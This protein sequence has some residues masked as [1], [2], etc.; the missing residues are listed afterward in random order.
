MRVVTWNI[1]FGKGRDGRVD[2]RR[3][4]DTARA[5]ADFDVLCLQEVAANHPTL[6]DGAGEDQPAR[7]AELL[8][9][10][11]MVFRPAIEAWH[12]EARRFGNAIFTRLPVAQVL[13]HLL[14]RPPQAAAKSMQRQALEVVVEA[15][16][17]PVRVVTT[18]LEYYSAE[19][20]AAQVGRLRELHRETAQ[21]A[22]LGE[23][24]GAEEGPYETLPRPASAIYCGDFNFEPDWPDYAAM[25]APFESGVPAL[26][27]AWAT[28]HRGAPHPPTCGID[29]PKQWPKGPHCRDFFFLTEVLAGRMRE[30]RADTE[31]PASDHQPVL[32]RLE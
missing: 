10:Y 26:H 24:R 18:H 2:L 17:G 3:I 4:V 16:F 11:A 9:G 23:A 5:L 27:D 13:S 22:A 8:P 20:R 25:T 21:R 30:V 6:D 29:D 14:P 19:H 1:Q 7:L 15:A 32:L 31:T 12:P 28:A